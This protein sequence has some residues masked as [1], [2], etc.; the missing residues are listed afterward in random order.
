LSKIYDTA[1]ASGALGGKLLGAG[2]GGFF[3]FYVQPRHRAE[4]SK[5]LKELGCKLRSV[6]FEPEGVVSWR[7]KVA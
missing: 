3:L 2:G 5:Q 1:L 4:V 6:R 7:T